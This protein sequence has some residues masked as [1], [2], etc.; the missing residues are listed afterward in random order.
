MFFLQM[1]LF[2]KV[3]FLCFPNIWDKLVF[4]IFPSYILVFLWE[5]VVGNSWGEILGPECNPAMDPNPLQSIT[6]DVSYFPFKYFIFPSRIYV[7]GCWQQL[8]FWIR[9]RIP[10]HFNP[11]LSSQIPFRAY[12]RVI[13]TAD[14]TALF[15]NFPRAVR[16]LL[17]P[18]APS[19]HLQLNCNSCN[20]RSMQ[21][22]PWYC[23]IKCIWS[24]F[25]I[26]K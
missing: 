25:L 24:V 11:L 16:S 2:W 17:R 13:F 8:G 1:R 5:E 12:L 9:R 21:S 22:L 15:T 4:F 6:C 23:T 19:P 14:P 20:C 3:F 7:C 18:R 26:F 10:I